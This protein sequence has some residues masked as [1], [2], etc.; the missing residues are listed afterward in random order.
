MEWRLVEA[1][2]EIPGSIDRRSVQFLGF[3]HLKNQ[4]LKNA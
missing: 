4:L 3:L 1:L 2:L